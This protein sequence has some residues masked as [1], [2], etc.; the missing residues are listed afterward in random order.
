[1]AIKH[2]GI[3]QSAHQLYNLRPAILISMNVDKPAKGDP[4]LLKPVEVET[5]F[6]EMGHAMHGLL[7]N[8]KHSR[9]AGTSVVRDFVELPSQL[10]EGF[11]LDRRFLDTFAKHH[12]TG[13]KIPDELF[14][15]F[16][17]SRQFGKGVSFVGNSR[18]SILDL[19][20]HSQT[21]EEDDTV[22]SFEERSVRP[23]LLI[24]P[25]GGQYLPHSQTFAHIFEGGYSSSYYGY[26][27]AEMLEAHA[28]EYMK[29]NGL[30]TRELGARLRRMLEQGGSRPADKI[31]REFT[32]SDPDVTPLKNRISGSS[33]LN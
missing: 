10:M 31:Y 4:T 12:L 14:Q 5:Y 32:G 8:V 3:R 19:D 18:M 17:A 22:E 13:A 16:I 1:M 6:H 7:A 11:Y 24:Q 15:A 28:F 23:Y 2:Q 21:I 26:L 20:W 30:V 25:P 33:Q 29:Q 27:W 9:F